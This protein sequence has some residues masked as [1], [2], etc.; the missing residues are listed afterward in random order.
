M[1]TIHFSAGELAN[2]LSTLNG[3]L[4]N[5]DQIRAAAETLAEVSEANTAAFN[6]HYGESE[7]PSTASDLMRAVTLHSHLGR[8][9]ATAYML[10]S[11]CDGLLSDEVSAQLARFILPRLLERASTRLAESQESV[12]YLQTQLADVRK[13]ATPIPAKRA[14]A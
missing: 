2:I 6:A 12:A 1:S 5:R 13:A 4:T 9:C 7:K 14:R 10:E 11:N 3:P 8:A